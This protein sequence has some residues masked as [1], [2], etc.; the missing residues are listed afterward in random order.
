[1]CCSFILT[2]EIMFCLLELQEDCLRYYPRGPSEL[3]AVLC[4]Q[5]GERVHDYWVVHC[6]HVYVFK[7]SVN[8]YYKVECCN[9]FVW[10][11][12]GF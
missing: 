12:Q 11:N 5:I 6:N 2:P 3:A 10:Y 7:T 1:M 9:L 4:E 8:K